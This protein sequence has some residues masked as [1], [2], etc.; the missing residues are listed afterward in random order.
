MTMSGL[1]TLR[2]LVESKFGLSSR[3][4]DAV[5]LNVALEAM[6]G[7]FAA[8][9]DEACLAALAD[10]P[11]E[12]PPWQFVIDQLRVGETSFLRHR[13]W[14]A[15]I[16][17]QILAPL[18]ARR[19]QHGPRRLRLWSAGCAT[20][21][22]AYSLA[23]LASRLTAG[24]HDWTIEIIATDVSARTLDTA[25]E[26]RFR[27][28]SLRELEPAVRLQHF[29]LVDGA[30]VLDPAIRALVTFLP[31]NLAEESYP[32][33]SRRLADCDLVVCRNVLM[34]FAPSYQRA[35]ATRLV[36]AVAPQGWLAV[37]PAE[38][39][40]EWYRPLVPISFREAI[41]FR[42]DPPHARP[43]RSPA[44]ATLPDLPPVPHIHPAVARGNR[45][46][47][48]DGPATVPGAAQ[49]EAGRHA[50]RGSIHRRRVARA[51]ILADRGRHAAARALCDAIMADGTDYEASL[52]LGA[53]CEEMGDFDAA[54]SAIRTALYLVPDS[55]AAHFLMGS[56]LSRLGRVEQAR[57][58]MATVLRLLDMSAVPA[59]PIADEHA[60]ADLRRLAATYFSTDR[61]D[62]GRGQAR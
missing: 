62:I 45:A 28:W 33:P 52:L 42:H 37:S 1:A 59:M 12:A 53:V 40:A 51:R 4:L 25:R 17:S 30:H 47:A 14:F 49:S 10:L 43:T 15:R 54:F 46:T 27:E 58:S 32:D 50:A 9:D 44:A 11:V 6:R 13:E 36:R 21:E 35:A 60:A 26:A 41:F 2:T 23:L 8:E 24:R 34:Y 20:G 18:V 16:E 39:N 55:A 19:A 29:R 3:D 31:L 5:R 38:A 7:T 57:R 56:V 48:A 22:E 61:K